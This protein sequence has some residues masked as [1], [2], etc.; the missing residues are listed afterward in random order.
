MLLLAAAVVLPILLLLGSSVRDVSNKIRV[1]HG[2]Q[3]G[4]A[5]VLALQTLLRDASASGSCAGDRVTTTARIDK[6]IAA[7]DSLERTYRF[8][9]E[10]WHSA[11]A[12][13]R[14]GRSGDLVGAIAAL[15]PL[16]SD[17]SGLTYDPDSA[18]IDLADALT[19]RL[20]VAIDQFQRARG[21]LCSRGAASVAAR[22]QLSQRAGHA[23]GY[24]DDGLSE[25]IEAI[26]IAPA[27][28]AAVAANGSRAQTVTSQA[29]AAFAAFATEPS[30]PARARASAAAGAGIGDL[31]G[32]VAEIRPALG[33]MVERRVDELEY[34]RNLQVVL[35]TIAI[36]A[37]GLI[38]IFGM[39]T[40]MQ[41][42]EL[43]RIR[44]SALEFQYHATHD[45]LT[46]LPNR[47]AL[48]AKVDVALDRV[49]LERGAVAVLFIDLDNFKLVND[50]LGH[51]AGDNV[52]CIV[53]Q[54]LRAI[55][56]TEEDLSAARFGGDEFAMLLLEPEA[57]RVNRRIEAIVARI[58]SALAEPVNITVPYEQR[59][60]IT[61]SV[62]VTMFD[63]SP[64]KDRSAA[65]LLREADAAMY[66]AKA[67]GRAQSATF[68]PAMRER[69]IRKLQLTTDLR[70]PGDRGELALEFQP[71]V[72]LLDD[73]PI[74]SEALLRWNHPVLGMLAPGSFLPLAQE[75]GAIVQIGR[76]VFGEALR[77]FAAG[78]TPPGAIHVNVSARELLE[79][80]LRGEIEALLDRYEI[81]PA[82]LAIEVVEGSL[83]RSGDRAEAMLRRLR[84]MGAKI[85]IDD[86]G[87]EYSS[88]R[89]LHRLPIDGVKID[90]SFVTGADGSLAS[91]S[92]VRLII[93]LARSLELS[94]VA[95]GIQ[96]AVQRDSLIELGCMHGQGFLFN[97]GPPNYKARRAGAE[98][99]LPL[100]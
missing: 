17:R 71:F 53:A 74:G 3:A 50:S 8:G 25:A 81:E 66:E 4:L 18:G 24:L 80:S 34:E 56:A 75:T 1:G 83:I 15:F 20:P 9:G 91:P 54:R 62:G 85:W 87:V 19:Y 16:V 41:R 37:A 22:L 51:A 44:R 61:A 38:V 36:V 90:R 42:A 49:R 31:Y 52:L 7:I 26:S 59:V 40:A 99:Y 30:A 98:S 10:E 78:T 97:D 43:A 86:F 84:A 64:G 82:R 100:R 27:L 2:E 95:E 57:A 73:V 21:L 55:C 6:D 60:V 77:Q 11:V 88:L 65:D 47:A 63:S 94:V 29:L 35:G 70:G 76:W 23:E 96:T 32:L 13:S 58:S 69:A 39:R 45:A 67:G 33:G 28:P 12:A 48:L 93:E 89:Y 46:G 14:G 79:T 72:R 92:I 5:Y 68:G